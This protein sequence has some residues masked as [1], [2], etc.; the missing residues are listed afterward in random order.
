[1]VA[2]GAALVSVSCTSV[3]AEYG[4]AIIP[5]AGADTSSSDGS[6]DDAAAAQLEQTSPQNDNGAPPARPDRN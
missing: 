3:V 6:N 5:D 2:A 4:V 1:M